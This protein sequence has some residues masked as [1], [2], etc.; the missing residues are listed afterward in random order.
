MD[1]QHYCKPR[2]FNAVSASLSCDLLTLEWQDTDVPECPYWPHLDYANHLHVVH[3]SETDRF[4]LYKTIN[5]NDFSIA[6][7]TITLK[8][9]HIPL[10]QKWLGDRKWN[11]MKQLV[12]FLWCALFNFNSSLHTCNSILNITLN[13]FN[14]QP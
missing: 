1:I 2:H 8:H 7:K 4:F 14:D 6:S 13:D 9:K 10:N 3:V 11:P 12:F 5:G